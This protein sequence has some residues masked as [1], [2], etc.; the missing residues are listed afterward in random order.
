MKKFQFSLESV[1]GYKQQ[2]LDAVQIELGTII[3]LVLQQEE[4]LR[5]AEERYTDTN[6]EFRERK[7]TGLT[8]ADAMS[9]EL[10]LRVLE[11]EI[12]TETLKL[13]EL[14]QRESAK[15]DELIASKVDTASLEKLKEKKLDG[16]NK[17]LQKSEELFIDEIVSSTYSSRK[18]MSMSS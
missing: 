17:A 18:N 12:Q 15:R 2:I 4:V 8:I 11:Q 1:L 14:R 7:Q 10:G 9:Y 5:R 13:E 16:Y 3:A 6:A